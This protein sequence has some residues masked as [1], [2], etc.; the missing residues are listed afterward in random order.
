M[1]DLWKKVLPIKIPNTQLTLMGYSVAARNTAFYIPE[2]KIMLD[3]G[4]ENEYIPDHIFITHC[5]A[6]HSKNIPLNIVQLSNIKSKEIV[7]RLQNAI[8][9]N[10]FK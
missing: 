3:C 6:D 2:M 5:H 9:Y 4:I 7:K 10:R 8:K 1:S